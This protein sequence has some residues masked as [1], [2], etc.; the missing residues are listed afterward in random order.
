[1][2][3][4]KHDSAHV[5][6]EGLSH[7]ADLLSPPPL[8]RN[9]VSTGEQGHPG[10]SWLSGLSSFKYAAN[11]VSWQTAMTFSRRVLTLAQKLKYKLWNIPCSETGLQNLLWRLH[12]SFWVRQPMWCGKKTKKP[13]ECPRS[14]V[15]ITGLRSKTWCEMRSLWLCGGPVCFYWACI[16]LVF[17]HSGH[18]P[19]H[20]PASQLWILLVKITCCCQKYFP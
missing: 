12:L 5:T 6:E 9:R 10:E 17:G 8:L 14:Q 7:W 1:M 13:T 20:G 2:N 16:S 4:T 3:P 18:V 11:W 15:L 19:Y